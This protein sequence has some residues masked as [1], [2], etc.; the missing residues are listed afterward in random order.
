M[1]EKELK[2]LVRIAKTDLEGKKALY[3]ALRKIKG[4]N[5]S[6]ANMVCAL[7][8]VDGNVKVG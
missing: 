6:F 5:F 4:V 2:H 7:T 8:K 3:Q 1:V